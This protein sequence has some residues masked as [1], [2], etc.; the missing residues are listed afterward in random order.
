MNSITYGNISK[1]LSEIT[2]DI[3]NN[4]GMH[5]A[6]VV[7][8]NSENHYP[9]R[10]DPVIL[11]YDR[12]L[13]EWVLVA[14]K[15]IQDFGFLTETIDIID[16]DVFLN[17]I[18]LDGIIWDIYILDENGIII[19]SLLPKDLLLTNNLLTGLREY[20]GKTLSLMYSFGN[21]N[22]PLEIIKNDNPFDQ[23]YYNQTVDI[24]K[25]DGPYDM[26][27]ILTD[28]LYPNSNSYFDAVILA[29]VREMEKAIRTINSRRLMT[30]DRILIVDNK[31][32]LPYKPIGTIVHDMAMLYL[33]DDIGDKLVAMEVT[34]MVDGNNVI[35]DELDD[36]NGYY[37]VVTYLAE[38][39]TPIL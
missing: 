38:L 9:E 30:T 2:T 22:E 4:N 11:R 12:N 8:T 21:N 24:M 36:V 31:I 6:F 37:A 32:T 10:E 25:Y 3:S 29:R 1:V 15:K 28:A 7:I 18:P 13:N 35:F 16:N 33:N 23:K 34:C 19:K 26:N 14:D 27:D 5:N 20:I 39:G 17:K